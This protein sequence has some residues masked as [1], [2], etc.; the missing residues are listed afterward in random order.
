MA[1]LCV[2]DNLGHV[3]VKGSRVKHLHAPQFVPASRPWGAPIVVMVNEHMPQSGLSW[4]R[5]YIGG[6]GGGKA[7]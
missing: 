7:R 5:L 3:R 2:Y 4:A 6:S 1:V